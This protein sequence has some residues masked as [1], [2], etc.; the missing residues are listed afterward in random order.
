MPTHLLTS[1]AKTSIRLSISAAISSYNTSVL[2]TKIA[3]EINGI[4]GDIAEQEFTN[5][6]QAF[7][8]AQTSSSPRHEL[9]SAINHLQSA[10]SSF[11]SRINSE[12]RKTTDWRGRGGTDYYVIARLR[13]RRVECFALITVIY[14]SLQEPTLVGEYI[15]KYTNALTTYL[16]DSRASDKFD[17][18]ISAKVLL[19]SVGY[20]W[21]RLEEYEGKYDIA[22]I[23]NNQGLLYGEENKYDKALICYQKAAQVNPNE[24]TYYS[25]QGYAL[26]NLGQSGQNQEALTLFDK[27]I[28]MRS[29]NAAYYNGKG[30]ALYRLFRYRDAAQAFNEAVRLDPNNTQYQENAKDAINRI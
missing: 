12:Y 15:N 30:L 24:A 18:L 29:D 25:N 19:D 10:A 2:L 22:L 9:T 13:L 1:L 16:D 27:A 21:S 28:Q 11:E 23:N 4:M 20:T 6:K 7:R 17:A 8:D 3:G 5:A 26:L 14:A